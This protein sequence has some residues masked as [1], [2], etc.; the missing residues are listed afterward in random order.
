MYALWSRK[1]EGSTWMAP[2]ASLFTR[3]G[4]DHVRPPSRDFEKKTSAP[5]VDPPHPPYARYR[6]PFPSAAIEG[7]YA[8][9]AGGAFT[10]VFGPNHG[11]VAGAAGTG[12]AKARTPAAMKA[13]TR[14]ATSVRDAKVTRCM[15]SRDIAPR[16]RLEPPR[17]P[18]FT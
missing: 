10:I 11:A 15:G 5:V 9:Y 8:V 7:W 12:I 4:A 2:P 18:R 17:S 1:R 3:N 13:N 16:L 6:T 14:L